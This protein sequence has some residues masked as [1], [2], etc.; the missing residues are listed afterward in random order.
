MKR[1]KKFLSVLISCYSLAIHGWLLFYLQIKSP[2]LSGLVARMSAF[3]LALQKNCV[4]DN[5]GL[6]HSRQPGGQEQSTQAVPRGWQHWL[7]FKM[8]SLMSTFTL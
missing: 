5:V 4:D 1:G 6:A 7:H 8:A 3:L 2:S